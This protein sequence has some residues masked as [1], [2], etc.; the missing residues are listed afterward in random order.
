MSLKN[1]ILNKIDHL[2]GGR[3]GIKIDGYYLLISNVLS[4]MEATFS[5]VQMLLELTFQDTK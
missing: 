1:L 5:Q 3:G 4:G 2:G